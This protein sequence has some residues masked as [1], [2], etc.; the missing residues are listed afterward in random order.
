MEYLSLDGLSYFY[1]KIRQDLS[2]R[3]AYYSDT[4]ANWAKQTSLVSK[5]DVMYIYT[6]R[7]VIN[8]D[9]VEVNVPSIKIGDGTTYVVDLPF[10]TVDEQSFLDH[11]NNLTVHVTAAEKE[12]W[13]NKVRCFLLP[14]DEENLVFT[15]D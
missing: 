5:K 1:S 15:T 12:A 10:V 9:G 6:D 14:Q 4:T 11:I 3:L 7:K 8:N 13:D 2:D